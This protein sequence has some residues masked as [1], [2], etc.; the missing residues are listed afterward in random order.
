MAF[1]IFKSV[2]LLC[3]SLFLSPYFFACCIFFT[4]SLFIKWLWEVKFYDSSSVCD[5]QG[6]AYPLKGVQ[7]TPSILCTWLA[8]LWGTLEI[9]QLQLPGKPDAHCA[10][11][12]V[13][14]THKVP[15]RVQWHSKG[16]TSQWHHLVQTSS[17]QPT[18]LPS[19]TPCHF[20]WSRW[21]NKCRLITNIFKNI[22]KT[23]LGD[24]QI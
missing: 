1:H 18:V 23:H 10:F 7:N 13:C 21:T 6:L 16:T 22:W 19:F 2:I 4:L 9:I 17:P 8:P 3:G 24:C 14:G 12:E 5:E 20:W 15:T 11:V